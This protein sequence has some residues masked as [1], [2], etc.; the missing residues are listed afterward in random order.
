MG[1][2]WHYLLEAIDAIDDRSSGVRVEWLSLLS[3]ACM[4]Q[5][6]HETFALASRG[7]CMRGC[8]V[9]VMGGKLGA[10]R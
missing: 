9:Q 4:Q 7:S 1:T 6:E 5:V 8:I 2:G 10:V 3:C